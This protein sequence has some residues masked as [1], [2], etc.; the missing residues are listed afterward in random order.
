VQVYGNDYPTA[1][2]TAVRDYIHILDLAE[3]HLLALE[4]ARKG[5]H[6][7]YNL[8]SGTGFSVAQVIRTAREVTGHPI[9]A[10]TA[11]RREGD[12]ATLVAASTKA[13]EKLGW[14]PQHAELPEIVAD[15]WTFA[16]A[17]SGR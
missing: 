3:A 1:D 16:R 7:I 10:S 11:P 9:P 17:R 8:G 15:A 13:A 12:P 5:E 2:G 6:A 14:R 4:H